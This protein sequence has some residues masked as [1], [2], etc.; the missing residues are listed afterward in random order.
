MYAL[1]PL[2]STVCRHVGGSVAAASSPSPSP[3]PSIPRHLRIRHGRGLVTGG[4]TPLVHTDV[5]AARLRLGFLARPL[6]ALPLVDGLY[7]QTVHQWIARRICSIRRR[8]SRLRSPASTT[9]PSIRGW[10][11][12]R[13]GRTRARPRHPSHG[14]GRA[15]AGNRRSYR[16]GSRF[17]SDESAARARPRR[18][19]IKRVVRRGDA[20]SMGGS[21]SIAGAALARAVDSARQLVRV[22]E[23]RLVERIGRPVRPRGGRP[24]ARASPD[25]RR[26]ARSSS[27]ARFC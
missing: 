22:G 11:C 7:T 17:V 23:A 10:A 1:P 4:S 19:V 25:E 18:V 20:S 14:A 9:E 15:S 6:P 5:S 16:R 24:R 13:R 12:T 3:F 21:F 8:H 26:G 27:R 2:V